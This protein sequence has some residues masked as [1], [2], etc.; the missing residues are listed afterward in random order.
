M[1]VLERIR[2]VWGDESDFE[3][4]GFPYIAFVIS[5]DLDDMREDNWD[6]KECTEELAD[7][8]INALRGLDELGEGEPHEVIEDRLSARMD[9]QV[10][11]IVAEYQQQYAEQDQWKAE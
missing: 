4:G 8:A 9:G 11:D 10:D 7:I 5:Q 2:E 1:D 6:D 3:Q